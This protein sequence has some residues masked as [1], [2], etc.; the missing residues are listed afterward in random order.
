MRL[1]P[2]GAPITEVDLT[3]VFLPRL[4]LPRIPSEHPRRELEAHHSKRDSVTIPRGPFLY[5][6]S[7]KK[8]AASQGCRI[9]KSRT[10]PITHAVCDLAGHGPK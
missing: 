2:H 7:G 3:L 5:H 1:P 4:P 10:M 9:V 6:P 8:A